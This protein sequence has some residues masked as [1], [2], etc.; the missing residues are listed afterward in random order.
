MKKLFVFLT[1]LTAFSLTGC[2]KVSYSEIS[3]EQFNEYY[4]EEKIEAAEESFAQIERYYL[5]C[6]QYEK[7]EGLD[8]RY[9]LKRYVDND[10]YYE[11]AKE[12]LVQARETDEYT[13]DSVGHGLYLG[14][15]DTDECK[16]YNVV[17]STVNGKDKH[18]QQLETGE[19]ARS[20]Y[21]KAVM[22]YDNMIIR[23]ISDPLYLHKEF[24]SSNFKY[25]KGSDGTLKITAT[26]QTGG[27]KSYTIVNATTLL[28]I[29][30]ACKGTV[31]N[32]SGETFSL[33]ADYTFVFSKSF[34][35][36][37]PSQIGYKEEE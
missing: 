29:K 2:N 11:Y 22:N 33:N 9:I 17:D 37:T 25:F 14:N 32:D 35:R 7:T 5:L 13:S 20:S 8:F 12:H 26:D 36:K 3:E 21:K 18:E 27:L 15:E 16:F 4:T 10:Y 6:D 30:A 24:T 19:S 34:A 1:A 28:P 31:T 23:I